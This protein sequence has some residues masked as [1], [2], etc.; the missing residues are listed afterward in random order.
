LSTVGIP[1]L[2]L[3]F[4]R[5]ERK[6]GL[7]AAILWPFFVKVFYRRRLDFKRQIDLLIEPSASAL[8]ILLWLLFP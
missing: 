2:F 7:L 5:Y 1:V 3:L 4:L 8:A 6:V